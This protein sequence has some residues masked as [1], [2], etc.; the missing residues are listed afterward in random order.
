MTKRK[1]LLD[2]TTLRKLTDERLAK[3]AGGS[4]MFVPPSRFC[5][6][7]EEDPDYGIGNP[8]ASDITTWGGYW[9]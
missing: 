6:P 4:M 1:L 8:T 7:E 5:E 3:A 9:P 2:R